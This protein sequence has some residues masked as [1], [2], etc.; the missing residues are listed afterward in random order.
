MKSTINLVDEVAGKAELQAKE[1]AK[2]EKE[3]SEKFE[4]M[5]Q[6]TS[7]L[8]QEWHKKYP[9][10]GNGSWKYFLFNTVHWE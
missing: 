1:E 10:T 9:K 4:F 2:E 5:R 7:N 8:A 6:L 3:W